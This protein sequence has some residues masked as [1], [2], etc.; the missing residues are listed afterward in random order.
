MK[1]WIRW[2]IFY[3][4]L[5]VPC[6]VL[7]TYVNRDWLWAVSAC[8]VASAVDWLVVFGLWLGKHVRWQP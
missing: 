7:V 4:L 2:A 5:N 1:V 6:S 3:A 8:A